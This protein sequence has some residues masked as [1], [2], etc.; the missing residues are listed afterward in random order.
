VT[1]SSR[2][3]DAMAPLSDL[4]VLLG[5]CDEMRAEVFVTM[6]TPGCGASGRLEG[7][8]VGPECRRATTLPVT[9]RLEPLPAAVDAKG[10]AMARAILTEPSY[11]SPAVPS[12]YRLRG[13]L[14][15]GSRV[16]AECDRLVGLRRLGIRGR[17]LW[18]DG[19]RWVPRAISGAGEPSDVEALRVEAASLMIREPS[20][21]LIEA[22]DA[23]GVP[24]L[25]VL[26]AAADA[27]FDVGRAADLITGWALHPSVMLAVIPGGVSEDDVRSLVNTA[28]TTKGTLL[29][30]RAVPGNR[31]PPASETAIL[32]PLLVELAGDDLPHDAWRDPPAVPRLAVRRQTVPKERRRAACDRLQA[33]LAA[34][35]LAAGDGRPPHDWAGYAVVEPS[36]VS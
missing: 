21:S 15:D 25:A 4:A 1:G 16:I 8:L 34:W 7:T 36:P 28:R 35:G 5:R 31:P 32:G 24:V 2:A 6:P 26:P 27:R 14:V 29:L 17:S 10:T 20:A 12:L 19:R 30:A 33:D 9:A 11:W 3:A 22:T 18:L 13:R 23:H